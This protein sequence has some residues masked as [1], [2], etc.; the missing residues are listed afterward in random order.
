MCSIVKFVRGVEGVADLRP[1]TQEA[2]R[3]VDLVECDTTDTLVL[4]LRC[5]V[6]PQVHTLIELALLKRVL[7]FTTFSSAPSGCAGY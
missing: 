2:R 4:P 7:I 1:V 6:C 5:L 3:T